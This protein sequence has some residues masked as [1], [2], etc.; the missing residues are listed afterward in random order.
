MLVIGAGAGGLVT[1]YI[2]AA[3]RAKVGLIEKNKTEVIV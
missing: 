3:V 2:A 1:A